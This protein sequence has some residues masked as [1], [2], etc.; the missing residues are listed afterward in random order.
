MGITY[1]RLRMV[2]RDGDAQYSDVIAI[3]RATTGSLV[4]PNPAGEELNVVLGTRAAVAQAILSDATGRPVRAFTV[5]PDMDRFTLPV[6]DLVPGHY[7]LQLL[8]A[9][10][11]AVDRM[12]VV[13]R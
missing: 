4:Y 9:T 2:D 11:E 3:A 13:K 7:T 1:Y 12:P 5:A 10:G 8:D 6:N